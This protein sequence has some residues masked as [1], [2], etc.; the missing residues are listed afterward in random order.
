[1]S[2]VAPAN[3]SIFRVPFLG[4][5]TPRAIAMEELRSDREASATQNAPLEESPFLAATAYD[6]ARAGDERAFVELMQRCR[7][8][9]MH[10][11]NHE[12]GDD[13]RVKVGASDLVQET[14]LEARKNFD[15]FRGAT[16][17]EL[18][19]WLKKI[20]LNKVARAGRHYRGTAMRDV[21]REVALDQAD[22]EGRQAFELPDDAL[23]PSKYLLAQERVERL[24]RALD[25]LSDAHRR[26]IVLR[27]VEKHSFEVIGQLMERSEKAAC[28]LWTRALES[29][30]IELG[31]TDDSR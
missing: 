10:V 21:R 1:M 15:R 20:L 23:T 31:P 6:A 16:D 17:K 8:Y 14:L 27:S 7:A 18:V 25:R 22:D 9:L 28:K 11:A 29:L 2:R 24:R 3:F 4:Q 30:R 5:S 19:A 12:V 13:L 26:V